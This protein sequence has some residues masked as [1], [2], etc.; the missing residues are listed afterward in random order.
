MPN[1]NAASNAVQSTA[2]PSMSD[3]TSTTRGT[4]QDECTLVVRGVPARYMQ[5]DL[6]DM[7]DP[8]DDHFNFL[9][10]PYSKKQHRSVT[11][12]F[13]NFTSLDAALRFQSHWSNRMLPQIKTTS[14]AEKNVIPLII[15]LA[16]VQGFTKNM[17]HIAN[18]AKFNTLK[19]PPQIFDNSGASMNFQETLRGIRQNR[20]K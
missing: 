9:F 8:Q 6:L 10:L 11:Y 14:D 5:S 16:Q 3:A 1:V 15:S 12:C 2:R 18:D 20:Q 19:F 7:W 13:I 4:F 17:L